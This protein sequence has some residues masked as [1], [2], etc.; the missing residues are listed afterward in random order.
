M[1]GIKERRLAWLEENGGELDE[2]EPV[3]ARPDGTPVKSFKNSFNSA[4]KAA[5]L[6]NNRE[7]HKRTIY[8]LRHTYATMRIVYSEIDI[9]TLAVN[10]GTSV[11]MI[12][13]HYSHLEPIMAAKR[14]ARFD[15]EE[16]KLPARDAVSFSSEAVSEQAG[17]TT[18]A[19]D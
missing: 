4:L 6:T 10:M 15:K 3:L 5:K 18:K 7:G 2:T 13:R 19:P 8:S 16:Y 1:R 14:L 9:H 12:E 17:P 11:P